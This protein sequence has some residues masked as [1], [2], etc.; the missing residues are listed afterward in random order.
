VA[1]I[2]S[3][4]KRIKTIDRQKTEN[5]LIK[6]TLST[7]I[8]KYKKFLIAEDLKGAEEQL[9]TTIAHI[10]SACSK[11]IIHKNNAS[12]KVSRLSAAFD[13]LKNKLATK[14]KETK[15]EE[16]KIEDKVE[17]VK[18]VEQTAKKPATKKVEKVKKPAT[19]IDKPATKKVEKPAAKKVEKPITKKADKPAAKKTSTAKPKTEKK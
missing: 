3:A 9:K 8:K 13:K 6:S 4:Q 17:E 11:G 12:R 19:K 16:K 2:K 5:R 15:V 18:S 14:V 7:Y 10:D 1:N